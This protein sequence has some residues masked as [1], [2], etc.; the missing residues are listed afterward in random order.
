[1]IILEILYNFFLNVLIF[2]YIIMFKFFFF[3]IF[4]NF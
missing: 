2:H 3:L 1:M 4:K